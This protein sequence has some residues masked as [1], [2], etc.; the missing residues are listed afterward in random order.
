MNW[1]EACE[2]SKYGTATRF[3]DGR[4]TVI[5]KNGEG[6]IQKYRSNDY[7]KATANELRGFNDWKSN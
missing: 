4:L 1:Q 7:R 2:K 6:Y 5:A 3:N